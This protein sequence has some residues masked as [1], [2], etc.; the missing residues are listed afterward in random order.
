MQ[1]FLEFILEITA[2]GVAVIRV[3]YSQLKGR[4]VFV[5]QD[6]SADIGW[7]SYLPTYFAKAS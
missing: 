6:R 7:P 4:T 2:V 5:P 1:I 3:I